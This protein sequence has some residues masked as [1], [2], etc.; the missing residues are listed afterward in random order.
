LQWQD[1]SIVDWQV[2]GKTGRLCTKKW[3]LGR[4]VL[5]KPL[6]ISS[7]SAVNRH[8]NAEDAEDAENAEK[9]N[10]GFGTFCAKQ[11]GAGFGAD[12]LKYFPPITVTFPLTRSFST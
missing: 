4:S 9:T 12:A 2:G 1:P 3:V 8:F 6:R 11:N 5:G 7:F 10:E